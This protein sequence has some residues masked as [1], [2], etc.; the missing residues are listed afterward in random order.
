MTFVYVGKLGGWYL[1]HEMVDFVAKAVQIMPRM[2]WRVL[3]QSDPQA[4]R[5]SPAFAL[6]NGQVTFAQVAP[7]EVPAELNKCHVGLSFVKPCVSK[8][9]SSPTKLA[10][11]LAAGLPVV[12]TAGIGDSD[13]ILTGNDAHGE[14]FNGNGAL[15][16]PV[17]VLVREFTAEA[18]SQV[19][20]ELKALLDDPDTPWRCR[21]VAEQH[22]DLERVGWVRYRRLYRLLLGNPQS[23]DSGESPA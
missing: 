21:A 4:I 20:C 19:I 6:L 14:E 2:R 5:Q 16:R 10:E 8:Q 13:A 1:T 15:G 18:Y 17:G 7:E 23:A 22:F 3:S 9:A 12:S 11:Y